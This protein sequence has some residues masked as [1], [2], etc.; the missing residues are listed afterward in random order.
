MKITNLD[1]FKETFIR[2]ENG[3]PT[4]QAGLKRTLQ[5]TKED[6]VE[7]IALKIKYFI[8]IFY[9]ASLKYKD[10]DFHRE[11]DF[12]FA[13]QIYSF[14]QTGRPKYEGII[15]IGFRES[16]KTT[17]VKMNQ[18][19][20]TVYLRD[21]VDLINA[22]SDDGSSSS[23][24]TMDMFNIFAFSRVARYYEVISNNYRRGKKESQTMSKFTTVDGVT[25]K[26]TG[27]RKSKRG[28]VKVDIDD[29]GDIENKRPKE[30]IFDDIE[31]ETSVKSVAITNTI[32]DVM[33]ATIDG[34]D[35]GQGFWI[36]LGN[37]L[38]LRGNVARMLKK[39][40]NEPNVKII[41]IP[42]HD[43]LKRPL[44]D[45]K[46][47]ATDKEQREL[48]EQGIYKVSIETLKRKSENFETEFL[49]NPKRSRVYFSTE[50][51]SYIDEESL[52]SDEGRDDDGLLILQEPDPSC[53]YILSADSA[54]GVGKDQSSFT[55]YKTT[56]LRFEEVANF[57][58]N[59]IKPE[60]F[61]T[62]T[63]NIATRYNTAFIIPENNYPGNEFI[64]FLRRI[65]KH[66]YFVMKG[67]DKE[68]G[69][70][71]NGKT[72]PEMFLKYKQFLSDK[73]LLI[74]SEALYS[75]IMEYPE[76]DVNT[77]KQKDGSGGHFDLLMSAVIGI[78]KAS[79]ISSE[80]KD[81]G[82]DKKARE[83]AND[84]FGEDDNNR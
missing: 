29:A 28:N 47:C 31:N 83:V 8:R 10:A 69:V 6:S 52:I 74:R 75:Q 67:E 34:L 71:T 15:I 45:A 35:Q 40:K 36:M 73:L 44:W 49:N 63:A 32:K 7:D 37:Y 26:A 58:S 66:I 84:I 20:L 23:E 27:S 81:E 4:A 1:K 61:A 13:E 11:I 78:Y 77:I 14:L 48:A 17:R 24:F 72:K 9:R 50:I 3:D 68:Y 46:Y 76:D 33:D 42:I 25:Y 64:A 38:S 65:Y 43:S 16:A 41:M 54:K 39:Y 62:Y 19:Y 18:S 21:M 5:P 55:V 60:K 51:I 82:S 53:V 79:A 22:V 30:A 2:A 12:T 57:Q 59:T 70:N 80:A 56:G